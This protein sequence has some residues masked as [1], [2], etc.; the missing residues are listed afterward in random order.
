MKT[1]TQLKE[2]RTLHIAEFNQYESMLKVMGIDFTKPSKCNEKVTAFMNRL[3]GE[4][5]ML[6][7]IIGDDRA[8]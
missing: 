2:I 4:I 1:K 6:N 8:F 5:Q 3:D 7:E